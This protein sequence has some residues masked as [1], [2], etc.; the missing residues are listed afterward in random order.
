M[1][2]SLQHLLLY[3]DEDTLN[4]ILTEDELRLHDY[5]PKSKLASILWKNPSLHSHS[6]KISFGYE[7][8]ISW[9]GYAY[10]VLGFS[11]STVSPSS[12]AW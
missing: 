4:R 5:Q 9:E 12:E 6:T 8:N 1:G 11:G 7:Y 10:C 3:A 2:L